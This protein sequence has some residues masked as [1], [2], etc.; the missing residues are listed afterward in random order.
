MVVRKAGI[1]INGTIFYKWVQLL[2]YADD[3]NIIARSRKTL[4]E[5][6]LSLERAARETGLRIN[7]KKLS[8]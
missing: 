2:A 5:A 6:F 3:I 4:K 8:T 7:K 1:Q